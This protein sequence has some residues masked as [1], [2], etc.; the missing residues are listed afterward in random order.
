MCDLTEPEKDALLAHIGHLDDLVSQIKASA[1]SV[2]ERNWMDHGQ[3]DQLLSRTADTA[4]AA[5]YWV[6][7]KVGAH[8]G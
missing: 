3:L 1:R 7:E 8:G 2:E 6:H 5:Q 4:T